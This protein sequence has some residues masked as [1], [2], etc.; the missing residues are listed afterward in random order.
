MLSI[1]QLSFSLLCNLVTSNTY[2][3]IEECGHPYSLYP[4]HTLT[5]SLTHSLTH[6]HTHTHTGADLEQVEVDESLF[7]DLGDLTLEE[8][9]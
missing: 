2:Y 5:L 4:K 3:S 7:Q 1:R 8:Q 6:P 9:S